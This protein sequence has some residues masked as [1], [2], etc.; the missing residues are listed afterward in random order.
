[1]NKKALLILL[2]AAILVIGSALGTMAYLTDLESVTNTFTVGRVDISL[3]EYIPG[4]TNKTTEG[5]QYDDIVPG[6]EYDKNPTVTIKAGSESAYVRMFVTITDCADM[7][8]VFSELQTPVTKVIDI[9]ANWLLKNNTKDLAGSDT[10]T[11]EFWYNTATT[12]SES[13]QDLPA[14]FTGI[15]VPGEINNAQLASIDNFK[16][17]IVAQAVQA[18]GFDTADEAFAAAPMANADLIP[19]E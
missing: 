5:N 18:D 2:S 11:Y 15:N 10:R 8:K 3:W 17:H 16:I 19:Q 7:D 4:T 14:L 13:E 1:M 9:N 6:G 12:K